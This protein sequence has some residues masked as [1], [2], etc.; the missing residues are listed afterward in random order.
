MVFLS[1][2]YCSIH[3]AF[4]N[5][6]K[7]NPGDQGVSGVEGDVGDIGLRGLDGSIGIQGIDGPIGDQGDPGFKGDIGKQGDPGDTGQRGERG[8]K[9]EIGPRGDKGPMGDKGIQGNTG[10]KGRKGTNGVKG[11]PG[12]KGESGSQL[13]TVQFNK[14]V[15]PSCSWLEVTPNR[16]GVWMGNLIN[17]PSG[18][19][20]SGIQS[21]AEVYKVL[22]YGK[23]T[24]RNASTLWR[25]KSSSDVMNRPYG[26]Y[27]GDGSHG[28][29]IERI[30]R[31]Y[32]CSLTSNQQDV[33]EYLDDYKNYSSVE[34]YPF[35]SP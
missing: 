4:T 9:G 29:Q 30:Y 17:C 19:A 2:Q 13:S 26:K 10:S 33:G 8:D 23:V 15:S 22:E 34:K 31:I 27:G 6:L 11:E 28:T 12:K 35:H 20:L 7:G 25:K 1:R 21:A 5:L 32:C 16:G 3:E 24:V 18:H 14:N